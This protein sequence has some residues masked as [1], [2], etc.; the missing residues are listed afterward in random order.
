MEQITDKIIDEIFS[1]KE[2]VHVSCTECTKKFVTKNSMH[3][4]R[5]SIHGK[6][7]VKKEFKC[8]ICANTFRD[9]YNLN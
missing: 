7:S 1:E 2:G 9:Q 4:H 3:R 8:D 6:E 5:N